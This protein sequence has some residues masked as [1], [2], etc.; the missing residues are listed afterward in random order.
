VLTVMDG[1]LAGSMSNCHRA[2]PSGGTVSTAAAQ[3]VLP[4][5]RACLLRAGRN[6]ACRP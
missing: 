3:L 2:M 1:E 6:R 5:S 4:P